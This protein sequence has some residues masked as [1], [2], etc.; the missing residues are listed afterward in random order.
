MDIKIL[1][2]S[3]ANCLKLEVLV[4]QTLGELGIRDAAVEKVR[5]DREMEHYLTGAPPGLVINE[6][7]V[8][9]GSKELPTKAQIA[10]WTREVVKTLAHD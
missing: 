7:L 6:Q 3:C 1:G 8:W 2:P 4:M 5:V 10:E 9:S